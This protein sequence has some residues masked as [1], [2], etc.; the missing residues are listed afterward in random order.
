M[1]REFVARDEFAALNPRWFRLPTSWRGVIEAKVGSA[2]QS[3]LEC[4]A[5]V[6]PT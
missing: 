2:K 5:K 3:T 6:I 1:P 4:E